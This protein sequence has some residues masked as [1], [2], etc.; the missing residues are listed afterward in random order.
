MIILAAGLSSRFGRN[1]MLELIGQ[2]TLL[3][4]VV[5]SALKSS[6]NQVIVVGGYSYQAVEK[7]L[8]GYRCDLVYNEDFSKGQSFSIRKGLSAIDTTAD[9]VMIQPGDM[10]LTTEKIINKVLVEYFLTRAPIV[11]AGYGGRPGHPILFDRSLFE[12]LKGI[13]EETRGLKNVVSAHIEEAMIVETSV[14]A[15]F[16]LDTPEDLDRLAH[17]RPEVRA[18]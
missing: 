2:T 5:G 11:S 15:L 8:E 1:K 10:A 3:R 18:K 4:H 7:A 13:N 14:G 6:V 16:D 17:L 12:E 9:A